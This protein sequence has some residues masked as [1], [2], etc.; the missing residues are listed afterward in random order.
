VEQIR[1]TPEAIQSAGL[2]ARS[3]QAEIQAARRLLK[4]RRG[5]ALAAL[6]DVF[7]RGTP[8]E[9][10]LDG[11]YR[12]ELLAL[13]LAPG[14]TQ[15][16]QFLAALWMPWR[17]KTFN[18]ANQTGDNVFTRDSLALGHVWWPLYRG[19]KPDEPGTYR[20][21]VFRT[22]TAPGQADPD[23]EVMKIDY[24]LPANPAATIRRVLDELVQLAD[25]LYLGKAHLHWWW[26]KWQPVAYFSLMR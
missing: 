12:G 4:S 5:E 11:R 15:F 19:Y 2:S 9:Q 6:N 21:F 3:A 24:D 18:A 7:R 14:L 26:G 25:G 17:G 1:S 20:A 16:S 10:A 13:D 23:R 8:P 22:Y